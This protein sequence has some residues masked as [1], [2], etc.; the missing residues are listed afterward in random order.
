MNHPWHGFVFLNLIWIFKDILK[1]MLLK[2]FN[3]SLQILKLILNQHSSTE[4]T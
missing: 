1:A 2:K 3:E 4:N